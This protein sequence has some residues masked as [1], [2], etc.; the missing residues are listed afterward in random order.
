MR[1]AREVRPTRQEYG[2]LKR[3]SEDPNDEYRA[4]R[5][6]VLLRAA[7]KRELTNKQLAIEFQLDEHTVSRLRH[8]F[9]TMRLAGLGRHTDPPTSEFEAQDEGSG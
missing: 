1:V 5:A 9:A 4:T 7:E 8:R 2:V 3:W 6:R